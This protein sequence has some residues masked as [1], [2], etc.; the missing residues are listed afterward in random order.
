MPVCGVVG[1]PGICRGIQPL[2]LAHPCVCMGKD[3]DIQCIP[4]TEE[5]EEAGEGEAEK[6]RGRKEKMRCGT[7]R[8]K[9]INYAK[10]CVTRK[11]KQNMRTNNASSPW[12]D[13]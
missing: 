12:E 13:F 4:E 1:L 2:L 5:R 3:K 8:N 9:N 7:S 6:E 11:Y 10:A